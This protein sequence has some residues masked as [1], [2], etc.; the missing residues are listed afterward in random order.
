VVLPAGQA[1]GFVINIPQYNLSIYHASNTAIFSDMKLIDELYE[2]SIAIVPIGNFLGMGPEEAAYA[3]KHFLPTA[4]M[5]IPS[6]F[7]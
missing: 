6:H 5:I 3:V 7:K 4:T 2:P 1:C